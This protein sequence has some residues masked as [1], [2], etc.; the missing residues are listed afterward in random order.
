MIAGAAAIHREDAVSSVSLQACLFY[1]VMLSVVYVGFT[2][3]NVQS[4]RDFIYKSPLQESLLKPIASFW[5][6]AECF[7][8][9]CGY[10][11]NLTERVPE[12]SAF[13]LV[14]I[15]PQLPCL[16]F[17]ALMQEHLFPIERILGILML[18]LVLVELVVGMAAFKNL[19][20]RQTAQFYREVG[21]EEH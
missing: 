18:I 7:R 12:T 8:L 10:K 6:F 4:K 1:N 17:L 15:F 21:Q 19:I 2:V 5:F 14:T 16:L 3:I 20:R 13:L 9:Y 11:G